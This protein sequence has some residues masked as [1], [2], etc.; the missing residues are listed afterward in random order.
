MILGRLFEALW[1]RKIVVVATSNVD[2]AD[3]YKDGL[4]RALFLPFIGMIKS[5]ME[6]V[7][8][9]SRTDFRLEKLGGAPVY[10]TPVDE[11]ARSAL[12]KAFR[13][14]AGVDRGLPVRLPLLGR[15]IAVPQAASHVARFDYADLCKQPLGAADFL[16]I[17]ETFHVLVVDNIPVIRPE[18]RNEAKRFI[19]LID[20]LYDQKVKLIASAEAEPELLYRAEQGREAFEFARTCSRLTEMRSAEYMALPH[21]RGDV[22]S[23]DITGL[24]ET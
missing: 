10:H 8:L 6:V 11:S 12:D 16:A 14:L 24:V 4:N 5:N 22:V 15:E 3:L 1:A 19:N 13:A 18:E 20:A 2:P 7:R 23:G 21:G 9:D 17:A